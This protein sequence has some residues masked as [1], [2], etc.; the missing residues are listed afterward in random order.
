LGRIRKSKVL[1]VL[2]GALISLFF[3]GERAAYAQ[4]DTFPSRT[5]PERV[6]PESLKG[7]G[8]QEIP[9]EDGGKDKVYYSVTTPEEEKEAR[10]EEKEKEDRSWDILKNIIIDQ[11]RR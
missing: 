1:I 6:S 7:I 9:R 2:L 3:W 4:S 8:G 10:Q 5:D 11:R